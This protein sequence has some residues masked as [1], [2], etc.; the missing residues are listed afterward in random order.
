LEQPLYNQKLPHRLTDNDLFQKQINAITDTN[1]EATIAVSSVYDRHVGYGVDPIQG[2]YHTDGGTFKFE[3]IRNGKWQP[4]NPTVEFVLKPIGVREPMYAKKTWN[5]FLPENNKPIGFDLEIGDW[6]APDGKGIT[7]DFI[8]TLERKFTSVTQDFS[9]TL[10]L[11][12][13]NDGDGIQSV[14]SDS[15]GSA[16]RIPRFAPTNNYESKLILQMYREDG[17]PRVGVLANP[18]QNYFFRVRTKKDDRGNI[19]SALYGK[20]QGGIG[21]DIFHSSTGQLIF[22]YY[23]NSKL[24]SQKTE[25]DPKQNLFKNLPPLERVSVP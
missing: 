13:P 23:L 4:W 25:F 14:M 2:F 20:I 24:N 15:S 16:L 12:F 3:K 18:D 17:K 1:G 22:S 5:V 9:A 7:T 8:F 21:W 10:T 19:V 6:V 11:T